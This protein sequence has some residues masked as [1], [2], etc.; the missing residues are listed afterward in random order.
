MLS[1]SCQDFRVKIFFL[2]QRIVTGPAPK[3]KTFVIHICKVLQKLATG[4]RRKEQL[5]QI[6]PEQRPGEI[7]L[8]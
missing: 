2:Y 5:K 3:V 7:V 1:F 8:M 6:H 4:I